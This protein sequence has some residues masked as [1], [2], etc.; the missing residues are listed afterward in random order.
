MAPSGSRPRSGRR[1]SP[2]R[3]KVRRE[4]IIEEQAAEA[5]APV[6]QVDA[7]AA[8]QEPA[9][10]VEPVEPTEP[11]VAAAAVPDYDADGEDA[12]AGEPEV[13][14]ISSQFAELMMEAPPPAGAQPPDRAKRQAQLTQWVTSLQDR[15]DEINQAAAANPSFP[16]RAA[17]EERSA[18]LEERRKALLE[19]AHLYNDSKNK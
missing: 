12:A 17:S 13:A 15:I 7:A 14:E 4:P 6:T 9:E 3:R 19:L 5:Q 16:A 10:P 2:I 18:L 1:R 11:A 8:P